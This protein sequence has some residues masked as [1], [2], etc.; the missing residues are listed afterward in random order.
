MADIFDDGFYECS[1]C[2][3]KRKTL[4]EVNVDVATS[5]RTLI[6]RT[7]TK[8]WCSKMGQKVVYKWIAPEEKE[9]SG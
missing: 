4:E 9:K 5:P 1:V 3:E 8:A 2:G 7:T 6:S